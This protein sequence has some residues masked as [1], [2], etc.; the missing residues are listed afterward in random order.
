MKVKSIERTM[1]INLLC[2]AAAEV[3]LQWWELRQ[4][5][6]AAALIARNYRAYCVRQRKEE[7]LPHIY[8]WFWT[9]NHTD[10]YEPMPDSVDW[11]LAR[12][13]PRYFRTCTARLRNLYSADIRYRINMHA[14]SDE[15]RQRIERLLELSL[16]AD[17]L[18]RALVLTEEEPPAVVWIREMIHVI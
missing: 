1:Q 3:F 10:E 7:E 14:A 9:M 5:E 17:H 15:L 6:K 12:T 8:F 16:W 13:L 11:Y 18:S 2:D 4:M